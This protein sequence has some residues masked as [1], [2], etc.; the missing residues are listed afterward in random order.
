MGGSKCLVKNNEE[1]EIVTLTPNKWG[2]G[3]LRLGIELGLHLYYILLCN[4]L[5]D[6][7]CD[8]CE[9][10]FEK[11]SSSMVYSMQYFT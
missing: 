6:R 7:A 1:K 11:L 10:I 3:V 9:L 2:K 5:R 8:M 4:S